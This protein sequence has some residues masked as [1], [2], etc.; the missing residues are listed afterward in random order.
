MIISP[1][2]LRNRTASQSDADWTGAMMPVNT[3]QGFPLNGAQSWH[4]GV[5]ITHTDS[6]T[7]PEK[8][9]AIADGVVVSFRQ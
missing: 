1:P 6:G 3:D 8:I 7:P 2:F 9:R 5:H 4:G